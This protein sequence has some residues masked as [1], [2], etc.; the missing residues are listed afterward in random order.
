MKISEN[1]SRDEVFQS[2]MAPKQRNRYLKRW[3]AAVNA[4]ILFAEQTA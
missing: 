1:W 2:K 4:T 3:A